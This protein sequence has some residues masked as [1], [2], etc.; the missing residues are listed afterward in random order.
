MSSAFI[1]QLIDNNELTAIVGGKYECFCGSKLKKTSLR[2]HMKTKK[3]LAKVNGRDCDICLESRTNFE[4]CSQCVHE[5]CTS[6]HSKITKC[7]FCRKEYE[8]DVD[9]FIKDIQRL[10][11]DLFEF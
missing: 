5:I 8:A 6:C 9:T 2:A 1:N 3:H 11:H 4:K 7:P 10:I